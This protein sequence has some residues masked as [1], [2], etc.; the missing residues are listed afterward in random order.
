M[1]RTVSIGGQGFEQLIKNNYFYVDKTQ[2]IKDWWDNGDAVTLITR[3]RRFGKTLNMDTLNCFFSNRYEGRG[4][5]FEGLD[6]WEYEKFREL[7]GTFPVIFI[8]FASVKENTLEKAKEQIKVQISKQFIMYKHILEEYNYTEDE[9]N[10]Y[11]KINDEMSDVTAGYSLNLLSSMLEKRYGQKVIILLD[12]YDT[13]LQEAYIGGYW[14]EMVSFV[15]SLFNSTFKTNPAMERGIMTGITRVSKE[16][17]FSDLNNL[18]VL[19]TT[20]DLYSTYFGFTS[21]EVMDALE[22]MGCDDKQ[23]EDVK[24]WYDGFTFG[25]HTDI[26]NPWSISNYLKFKKIDIYWAN[27][28]SNGLIGKLIRQG[29]KEVKTT[30][31]DLISG[32]T[33]AAEIDEEIVFDQ[34]SENMDAI[35][36]LLLASGY[37][38]VLSYTNPA[39]EKSGEEGETDPSKY[40]MNLTNLEVKSMFQR[41]IKGWFKKNKNYNDFV[42]AMLSANLREMNYY[43]NEVALTTFSSFDTGNHPS[44]RTEPER[45]YH[46]F[47]L[48]LMVDKR[49]DY[50]IRSNRES[51]LGRYDVIMKPRV[52]VGNVNDTVGIDKITEDMVEPVET[53]KY[54]KDKNSYAATQLPGIIL[55]FKVYDEEYDGEKTLSDT[56]DNA[57]KQIEEKQYDAELLAKGLPAEK[58]YKYGFAFRGKK[59]LIKKD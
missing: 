37:L 43:M 1:G 10:S 3:P 45:F 31:E 40:V 42:S 5:L 35:W 24:R 28:S 54:S 36:S 56:A 59:V 21:E 15:R 12:E 47:V 9:I 13:P 7:Q 44:G 19:T 26:Y 16:S 2:F 39:E 25:R 58:I 32:K 29:E 20:S 34:L 17:I 27:T 30:F 33:V 48:G 50:I 46:G 18:V 52:I 22:E 41:L 4:D 6:I 8:S 55:E 57:L 14:D 38:K 49:E 51:G 11:I 53:E 23:K